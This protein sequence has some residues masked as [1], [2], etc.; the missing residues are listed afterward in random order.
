M[1]FTLINKFVTLQIFNM[2][3]TIDNFQYIYIGCAEVR[4]ASIRKIKDPLHS[5]VYPI[6]KLRKPER[7]PK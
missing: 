4:S 7:K 2:E 1:N 5:A 6:T 3:S